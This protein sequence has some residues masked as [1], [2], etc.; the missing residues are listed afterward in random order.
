MNR[1]ILTF[2]PLFGVFFLH[3]IAANAYAAICAPL[4]VE[5]LLLA[6]FTTSSP[7]CNA[8]LGILNFSSSNYSMIMSGILV[9]CLM[10]L[11]NT[12]ATPLTEYPQGEDH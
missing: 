12:F 5:G 9:S 11:S 2:L 3:Y 6:F 1:I 4:S 8:L 10:I 7:V